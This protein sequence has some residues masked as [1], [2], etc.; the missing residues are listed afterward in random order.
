[1]SAVPLDETLS[2]AFGTLR[3]QLW[4]QQEGCYALL[5][6]LLENA[7]KADPKFRTVK[8]DNAKLKATFGTA[9]SRILEVESAEEA[10][11]LG[12]NV[13]Q[14]GDTVLLSPACASFDLFSSYEE[15]GLRFKGGVRS[16]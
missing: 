1:M 7:T 12:Y 14:P 16:L 15:R 8:K 5:L 4:E 9:V 10:A 13:A 6:K 3:G 2:E 11:I